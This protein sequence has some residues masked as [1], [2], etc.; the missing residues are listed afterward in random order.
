MPFHKSAPAPLHAGP[1]ASVSPKTGNAFGFLTVA[2]FA[3]NY[4]VDPLYSAGMTGA[5]RTI[6]IM[7]S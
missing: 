6:R 5:G 1:G 7:T 4:H 2:A 3:A